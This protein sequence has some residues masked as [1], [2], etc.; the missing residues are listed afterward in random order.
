[1]NNDRAFEIGNLDL[2]GFD[3]LHIDLK[4]KNDNSHRWK[5]DNND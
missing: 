5:K 1:M 4:W 3:R 2:T